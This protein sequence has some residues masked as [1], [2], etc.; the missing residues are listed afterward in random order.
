MLSE[1]HANFLMSDGETCTYKDLL[2]LID[3]TQKTVKQRFDI[4]LENEVRIITN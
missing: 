3:L 2:D 1:K 4:E